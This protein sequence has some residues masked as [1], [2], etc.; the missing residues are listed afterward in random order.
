MV[1]LC[2][3]H[4]QLHRLIL[5]NSGKSGHMTIF[6]VIWPIFWSYDQFCNKLTNWSYDQFCI[7]LN[8]KIINHSLFISDINNKHGKIEIFEFWQQ[9]YIT[10]ITWLPRLVHVSN[11]SRW[12]D[13]CRIRK[14]TH[15]N[16]LHKIIFFNLL[17][18]C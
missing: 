7:L 14:W 9:L 15:H 4:D 1:N 16:C 11:K 12:S 13:H 10:F 17:S 18:K 5:G 6:L 3:N 8:F 2:E